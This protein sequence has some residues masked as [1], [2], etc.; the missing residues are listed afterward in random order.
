MA[1]RAVERDMAP[2]LAHEAEYLAQAEPGAV[3]DILGGKE[4]LEGA[5]PH[6]G[7]HAGAGIAA[8]DGDEAASPGLVIALEVL[9]PQH[10]LAHVDPNQ[11]VPL[12]LRRAHFED[13]VAGVDHQV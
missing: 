9:L 4:R 5:R 11:P 13:R 3:P 12:R 10:G 6:L 1:G 2:E 7:L 8:L